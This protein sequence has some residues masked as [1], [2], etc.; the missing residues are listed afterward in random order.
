E[1][2]INNAEFTKFNANNGLIIE[3]H[4]ILEAF[5]HF[6]YKYTEGYLVVYD[7]QGVDL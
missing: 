3:F 4:P 5:A 2:Y 7:L 1:K 6:T